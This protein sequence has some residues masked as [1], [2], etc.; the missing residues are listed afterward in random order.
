MKY[1]V[2]L[3]DFDDTL[4]WFDDSTYPACFDD[5]INQE[6]FDVLIACKHRG[7]KIILHTCRTGYALKCAVEFCRNHG[8]EFDAI[9][10]DVQS[11]VDSWRERVPNSAMSFK[12]WASITIDNNTWPNN[13]KGIDWYL[14]GLELARE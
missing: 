6:A 12:P 2:I 11:S 1:P 8:L 14:L 3:C 4:Y 5:R 9:N 10:Q 7:Q 13:V